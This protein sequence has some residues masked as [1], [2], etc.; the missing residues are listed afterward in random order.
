MAKLSKFELEERLITILESL[1]DAE[2]KPESKL[3][4]DL[5]LDSMEYT[6]LSYELESLGYNFDKAFSYCMSNDDATVSSL[7]AYLSKL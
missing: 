2:V 1:T 5:D 6:D 7:A 4:D 3:S